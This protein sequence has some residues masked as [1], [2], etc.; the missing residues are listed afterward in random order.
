MRRR[1]LRHST[2]SRSAG[3]GN[4]VSSTSR[5]DS[6]GSSS[7]TVTCLGWRL[8]SN[9]ARDERRAG[10]R[11]ARSL[12]VLLE[13]AVEE[14]VAAHAKDTVG[15]ARTIDQRRSGGQTNGGTSVADDERCNRDL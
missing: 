3:G 8:P 13:L 10:S 11:T 6:R 15:G 1:K 2:R 4:G 7:A 14:H 12:R 9:D 5:E